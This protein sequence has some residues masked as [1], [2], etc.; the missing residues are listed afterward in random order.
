MNIQTY[1]QNFKHQAMNSCKGTLFRDLAS[2]GVDMVRLPMSTNY[3]CAGAGSSS[4]DSTIEAWFERIAGHRA[5]EDR[6]PCLHRGTATPSLCPA[7]YTMVCDQ[8]L[9]SLTNDDDT[10]I[11]CEDKD[12]SILW[13]MSGMLTM[14]RWLGMLNQSNRWRLISAQPSKILKHY[15]TLI[16]KCMPRFLL[17][18]GNT[19]NIDNIP[20][21]Y[22]T[23]KRKCYRGSSCFKDILG[24]FV[25]TEALHTCTKRGHICMRNIVSFARFPSAR[26]FRYI[27]RS[28]NHL[29]SLFYGSWHVGGL[30][31]SKQHVHAAFQE[32]VPTPD[33]CCHICHQP[34]HYPTIIT[35]D[36]GQAFEVI[37]P[38]S[39][40]RDLNY[41]IRRIKAT[42]HGLVQVFKTA[43]AITSIPFGFQRDYDDRLVLATKTLH[44]A[45]EA[46][47]GFRY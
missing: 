11:T 39:V 38:R 13:I 15:R 2:C 28:I 40:L 34:L 12:C 10:A 26:S 9:G 21:I 47:L 5:A 37:K 19:F 18:Q 22:P 24:K 8:F 7:P 33:H 16:N 43:E 32:L 36:A 31:T 45:V 4:V 23:I 46:Y 20:L 30:S 35:Y 3:V 29:S 44:S 1:V 41:L 27:S 6:M 17:E 25:P 42:G 14:T